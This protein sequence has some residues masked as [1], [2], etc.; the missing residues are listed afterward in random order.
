MAKTTLDPPWTDQKHLYGELRHIH[1]GRSLYQ[2]TFFRF[3]LVIEEKLELA[4]IHLEFDKCIDCEACVPIARPLKT[5]K[6]QFAVLFVSI[7]K[8]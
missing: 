7:L 3:L 1:Q 5:L 4:R 2:V 8:F 6:G